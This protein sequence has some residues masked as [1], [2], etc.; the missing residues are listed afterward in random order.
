ML[1]FRP[2]QRRR[3]CPSGSSEPCA[4][5]HH[6]RSYTRSL[7][8]SDGPTP[9]GIRCKFW[10]GTG[11][12][13]DSQEGQGPERGFA[14]RCN[15]C[16]EPEQQAPKGAN[17]QL[18]SL[19]PSGATGKKGKKNSE[20]AENTGSNKNSESNATRAYK[21]SGLYSKDTLSRLPLPRERLGVAAKSPDDRKRPRNAN[22]GCECEFEH[23]W[24]AQCTRC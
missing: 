9:I 14:A 7:T 4:A 18:L 20:D 19:S 23:M 1:A 17:C 10:W 16:Q 13:D 8:R 15:H 6:E 5:T 22:S 24:S 21:K 11:G 12:G 3:L 2:P